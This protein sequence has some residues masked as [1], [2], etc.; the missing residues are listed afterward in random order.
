MTDEIE[1]ERLGDLTLKHFGGRHN[2]YLDGKTLVQTTSRP[3]AELLLRFLA[4]LSTEK[5]RELQVAR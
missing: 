3:L 5:L 2:I 1:I 4:A